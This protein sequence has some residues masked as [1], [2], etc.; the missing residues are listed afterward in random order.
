MVAMACCLLQ[1]QLAAAVAEAAARG[2]SSHVDDAVLFCWIFF[3]YGVHV[4]R[5]RKAGLS[6][7]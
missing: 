7:F 2:C 3:V 4:K 6:R 1:Q 5:E